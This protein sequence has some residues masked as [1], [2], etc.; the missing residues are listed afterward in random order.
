[1]L[2]KIE[3]G[4][5]IKQGMLEKQ[6]NIVYLGIGSN[7]GNKIYNIEKAKAILTENNIKIIKSSS[8]YET[9]SW[10]DINNPKFNNI[11]LKIKTNLDPNSLLS[12]CKSIEKSMGRKKTKKN[13]PRICDIDI[14]DYNKKV[15]KKGINLPHSRMHKRS[16]VL[17]PLFEIEKNWIHPISKDHI[18]TLIFYLSNSDISS[19]KQI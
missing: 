10:P 6:A 8:Y 12:L 19:I 18:K 3:I 9:V 14:L 16:F 11:V 7:L 13:A 4:A 15:F 17:V 1:M 5:V 2:K